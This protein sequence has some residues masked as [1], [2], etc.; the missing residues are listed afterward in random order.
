MGTK[1]ANLSCVVLI[2]LLTSFVLLTNAQQSGPMPKEKLDCSLEL[3]FL[4]YD[5]E[6]K[7]NPLPIQVRI[8]ILHIRDIPDSGGSFGV[9]IK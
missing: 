2:S 3:N 5:S 4:W 6:P 1:V 9:D 8:I 7:G